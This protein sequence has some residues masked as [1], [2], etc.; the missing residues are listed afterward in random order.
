MPIVNIMIVMVMKKMIIKMKKMIM[1]DDY[2]KIKDFHRDN[3]DAEP[4]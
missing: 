1:L 2:M 4:W 3:E